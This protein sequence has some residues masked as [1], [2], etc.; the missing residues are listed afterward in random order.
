MRRFSILA[1]SLWLPACGGATSADVERL[2]AGVD[3]AEKRHE[4][5]L[6]LVDG[7]TLKIQDHPLR[8]QALEREVAANEARIAELEA[9]L[10]KL[11]GASTVGA[12]AP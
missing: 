2:Q 12:K 9:R 3:A 11:E 8:L 1:L 7:I 5:V 4:I 6:G 10:S